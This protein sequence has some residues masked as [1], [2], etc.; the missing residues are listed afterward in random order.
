MTI[1][2]NV[3]SSLCVNMLDD[4][5]SKGD[6]SSHDNHP[7]IIRIKQHITDKN[8]CFF[9][10][11]VT[12]EEITSANKRL[13]CKKPLYLMTYLPKLFSSLVK[14]LRI[15]FLITSIVALGAVY[16]LMNSI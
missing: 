11:N 12:K 14:V 15:F 9:F 13:T 7:S 2:F 6:V 8:K 1:F 5:S 10:R 16:F 4:N 3:V